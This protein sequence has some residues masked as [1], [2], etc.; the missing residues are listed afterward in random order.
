MDVTLKV[1][2][3]LVALAKAR[4]MRVE[5]Y[6]EEILDRKWRIQNPD[7]EKQRRNQSLARLAGTVLGKDSTLAR[8]HDA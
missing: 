5:E 3:E 1:S 6:L 4:G 8:D 2:D 7:Q